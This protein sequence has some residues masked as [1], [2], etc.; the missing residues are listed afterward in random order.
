MNQSKR[1]CYLHK[2]EYIP[3]V[4][5]VSGE[6]NC[7]VQDRDKTETS[8]HNIFKTKEARRFLQEIF[9]SRG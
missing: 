6:K 9:A 8:T 5:R 1:L 2:M 3:Y 4:N 7:K